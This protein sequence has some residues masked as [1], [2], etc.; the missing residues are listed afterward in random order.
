MPAKKKE[1]SE[2]V[3]V[4]SKDILKGFLKTNKDDHLNFVNQKSYKVSSGSLILDLEMSLG[5][6]ITNATGISGGG[7]SSCGFSFLHNFLKDTTRPRKGLLVVSEG[8]LSNEIRERSGVIFTD[9]SES[10]EKGT[11]FIFKTN[12]YETV[13]D[14]LRMLVKDNPEDIEYFIIIDSTNALVPKGD[15]ERSALDA[16][17]V[18][19]GALLTSD[20]LRKMSLA[21]TVKGHICYMISQ[22]R[23]KVSINPYEKTDPKLSNNSG[24]SAQIHY[25]DYI[26]EFQPR[27]KV[28]LI[29]E[30]ENGKDVVVGHWAKAIFRKSNSDKNVGQEVKWPICHGR[31]GGESV[32]VEYEIAELLLA[33][34]LIV[35]DGS[36]LTTNEGFLQE[37]KDAGLDFPESIQGLKKMR[38]FLEENKNVTQ[39]LFEKFR[40]MFS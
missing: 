32:W 17:K 22:V 25:S 6:G 33:Y 35:K 36:W 29:L 4:T 13:I 1:E 18:A 7:K 40:S 8:R 12:V 37:M 15:V 20:F 11:C 9:N 2:E 16:N 39:Y 30:K 10:W 24:G 3:K 14:L 27:H 34:E 31:K 38:T 5:P 23:S 19:G 28:D 26:L 21:F